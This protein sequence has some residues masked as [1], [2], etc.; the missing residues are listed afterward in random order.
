MFWFRWTRSSFGGGRKW[1]IAIG[2][3]LS[4]GQLELLGKETRG[5][6]EVDQH[7]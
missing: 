3:K 1:D 7:W 6:K 2:A 5:G 4:K